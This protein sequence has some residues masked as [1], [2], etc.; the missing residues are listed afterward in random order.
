ML[1]AALVIIY[2]HHFPENIERLNLVYGPKFQEVYHLVPFYEGGL[3]NVIPVY[4]NSFQ[5]QGFI[6]QALSLLS[7]S[8]SDH[9]LFIADD[10]VLNPKVDEH[11]YSQI[12]GVNFEESF[13]PEFT[14]LGSKETFW[15]RLSE[16]LSWEISSQGLELESLLPNFEQASLKF[17]EMGWKRQHIASN[18]AFHRYLSLKPIMQVS[19]LHFKK[20]FRTVQHLY[21]GNREIRASNVSLARKLSAR[22]DYHVFKRRMC[23]SYPLVGGYSDLVL[24]SKI[25]LPTFSKYCGLFAASGLHVELALPTALVLTTRKIVTQRDV[26]RFGRAYWGQ[27]IEELKIYGYDL[28]TLLNNFPDEYLFIHPIKLSKWS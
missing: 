7:K 12:F 25:D 28:E 2:N 4:G 18:A 21:R 16:A 26:S 20:F 6:P 22:G 13:F 10:M 14:Q 19:P 11:T 17:E 27:D 15:S 1:S 3:P 9:F 8:K 5:F 23:L 24:I